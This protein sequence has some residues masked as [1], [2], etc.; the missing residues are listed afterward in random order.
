MVRVQYFGVIR[1]IAGS[2]QEDFEVSGPR[3]LLALLKLLTDKYGYSMEA[4]L[5]EPKSTTPRPIHNF[6]VNGV[7]HTAGQISDVT[8]E[9]DSVV[10]IVPTQGG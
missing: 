8:P 2:R 7:V 1:E 10:S 9:K 4:Y 6:L 3:S 5:F